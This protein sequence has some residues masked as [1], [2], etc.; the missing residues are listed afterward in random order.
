MSSSNPYASLEIP[1]TE[2]KVTEAHKVAE[3]QAREFQAL[4][5]HLSV[6]GFMVMIRDHD[7]AE[8]GKLGLR[9]SSEA[10]VHLLTN[11]SVF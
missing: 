6:D 8:A 10:C 2:E 1:M 9:R 4:S 5:E 7:R 11:S 3:L